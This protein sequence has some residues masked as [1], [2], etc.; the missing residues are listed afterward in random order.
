LANPPNLAQ[1]N[2]AGPEYGIQGQYTWVVGDNKPQQPIDVPKADFLWRISVFGAVLVS[3]RYGTKSTREI[4]LLQAPVV[5]ALPGQLTVTVTPADPLH[6]AP[7][8]CRVTLTQATGAP[9]AQARKLADAGG[10]AVTLDDG[11]V[12]FTA[13]TASTLTIAGVAGVA[14]AATAS[15]PLVAGAVLTAGKGFQEFEP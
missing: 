10:G 9:R 14:V 1:A 2:N 11:A 8:T 5:L 13:L 12:S 6:A 7:V 4:L 3:I 15:V